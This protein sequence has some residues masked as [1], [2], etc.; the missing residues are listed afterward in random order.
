MGG[1]KFL[2]SLKFLLAVDNAKEGQFVV[3]TLK[4]V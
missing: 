2:L 1:A 4:S 3:V